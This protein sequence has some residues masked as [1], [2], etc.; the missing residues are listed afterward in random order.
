MQV[1][2][3]MQA[4]QTH[5]VPTL[6]RLLAINRDLPGLEE[7][8]DEATTIIELPKDW[9]TILEEKAPT[10]KGPR[11]VPARAEWVLR[12][13]LDKLKDDGD[14]GVEARARRRA[15]SLLHWMI[16]I[17]PTSRCAPQLRDADILS[18][19]ERALQEN[20]GSDGATQTAQN[21]SDS[22]ARERSE[23]R[24]VGKECPV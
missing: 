22:R 14:S 8:I 16:S 21:S 2:E 24:R 19:L 6:P 4:S 13:I 9:E 5:A 18:I 10:K 20:F 23:E 15:W 7:Q 12:W 17:V 3:Q 1:T 11:L